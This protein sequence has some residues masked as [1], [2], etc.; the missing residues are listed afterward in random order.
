V[1]RLAGGFFAASLAAPRSLR[2]CVTTGQFPALPARAGKKIAAALSPF[3]PLRLKLRVAESNNTETSSQ[4]MSSPPVSNESRKSARAVLSPRLR[5]L[6][7]LVL[8]LFGL[9]AVNSLYLISITGAEQLS[10]RSYQNYFYLVMFLTHLGLGLLLIVPALVFG[11]LHLRR[12][13]RWRRHKRY[14]VGAGVA[15]YSC[16]ILLLLSGVLLTRF[17]FFEVNDPMIRRLAYWLHVLTPVAVIWLFVLHRLAG[18]RLRWRSGMA[19]STAALILSALALGVHLSE[20]DAAP[21]ERPFLPALVQSVVQQTIPAAH[22]STDDMCGE[23]HADILEQTAASMHRLSSFNNPAYRFSVEEARQ[24]VLQRDGDVRAAQLCAGCHD[25]VPLM[26]GRFSDPHYDPDLDPNA[27][28][29]ITCMSCHAISRIN[30]PRGNADYRLSDPPRYPFA[31]S[32]QPLLRAINRQLIKAKPAFHK[33]TLLKPLHKTAEF[34]SACHKVHLPYEL[35]HYR[36]LRGQNHY[37]SFLLSGVSGHRVDSFY[38]PA[39]AAP[40]CAHCHMP[41]VVS[42]DPAARDFAASGRRMVHDHRFAAANT[43]VPALLG[44]GEEHNQARRDMLAKAARVDIF[45]IREHGSVQGRLHAPL[46]PMLP[47]LEPGR[48]YLLET[49]VRTLGVGHKLTQGTADSNELWLDVTLRSGGRVI[50]RSGALDEQGDADPWAYYL[51]AYLLDRDGNRIERR[52]AQDIFVTL[53]DHQIPPGAAS[54]AHYAFRVPPDTDQPL[55]IEVKLQYRKFDT[56]FLRHLQGE[57]FQRNDLPITTLAVD[58]VTLPLAPDTTAP[59]QSVSIP[60]W[61]RWNDYGIALLRE[62][63]QGANKGELRAATHAFREVEKLGRAD[64]P[65]NLARVYYKEGRLDDAAAALRRAA[66]F[67]PPAPPWTLT[68]FAALVDRERGNLDAAITALRALAETRFQTAR[69]RG[70]DFGRDYR[71]LSELG[72]TLYERARRERGVTRQAARLDLLQQ[73]EAQ[74]QRVL[75]L[76]PENLSAHYNLALVYAELEQPELAQLTRL[77]ALLAYWCQFYLVLPASIF[78]HR[79]VGTTATA[80]PGRNLYSR[81]PGVRSELSRGLTFARTRTWP[82]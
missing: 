36:W 48:R 66:D 38:Y 51:N 64:G 41:G 74:L 60:V 72:R 50:G 70:F 40:N 34:C 69:E 39:Q 33:Q 77:R 9:L 32:E 21:L 23:C 67:D 46:R 27:V 56:R 19:W 54:V 24:V 78:G 42:D 76:D 30:S 58:R 4:A 17:G 53:Y 49:V 8:G 5:R 15:L 68:W 37:D 6:L 22:L 26:S 14:A 28:A 25:P 71:M 7:T 80:C 10:G 3:R 75:E 35:N 59:Q 61:E 82:G 63:N 47:A 65:L 1:L 13:W 11:A 18:P 43:A 31:F 62:G 52:N 79:D 29:G 73:A 12:A 2:N 20:P 81:L 45:G 44:Q 55:S 16:A 57:D